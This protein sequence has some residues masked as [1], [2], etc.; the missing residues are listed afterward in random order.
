MDS[1]TK[2][3][4]RLIEH[5]LLSLDINRLME[6]GILVPGLSS[7]QTIYW[8]NAGQRIFSATVAA[9]WQPSVSFIELHFTMIGPSG[10]HKNV[11]QVIE[12]GKTYPG[13]GRVQFWFVDDG[14]R[15]R[16][17]YLPEGAT[18]FRSRHVHRLAYASERLSNRERRSRRHARIMR[19]LGEP[20]DAKVIPSK[21][22]YM[23]WH[24]Y[25]RLVSQLTRGPSRQPMRGG[26][27]GGWHERV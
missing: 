23:R 17:L 26:R 24:T 21:P 1:S 13:F 20:S 9:C 18:E 22:K 5:C 15:V 12:I 14:R 19:K 16:T 7:R 4:T 11:E 27:R 2:P 25:R 3:R 10:N 8:T 6:R